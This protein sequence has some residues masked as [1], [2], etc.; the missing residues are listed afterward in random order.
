MWLFRPLVPL[1][2]DIL[3]SNFNHFVPA[4]NASFFEWRTTS[5]TNILQT[6]LWLKYL[7]FNPLSPLYEGQKCRQ[8]SRQLV[9]K[10]SAHCRVPAQLV[11][12][13]LSIKLQYSGSYANISYSRARL[14]E[15]ISCI[16]P[17]LIVWFLDHPHSLA[18]S[19]SKL[20]KLKLSQHKGN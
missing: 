15:D 18:R 8:V 6:D 19:Y 5:S 7:Y 9:W 10:R 2:E 16:S 11:I 20:L 4:N 3:K 1:M 12:F 13:Y 14:S 17:A